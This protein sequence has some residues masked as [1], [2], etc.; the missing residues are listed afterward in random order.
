M[1]TTSSDTTTSSSA[2]F[3]LGAGASVDSGLPTYRGCGSIYGD[4]NESY[5]NILT[6]QNPPDKIWEILEPLY[7][8]IYNIKE[9]GETYK[10]LDK[11]ITLKHP[12]SMIVT[13][14]ID[15]LANNI[16]VPVVEL[17]NNYKYIDCLTCGE[18]C[19]YRPDH[20][21]IKCDSEKTMPD[22]VL[23]GDSI[24]RIKYDKIM[25]FIKRVKPKHV[26]IIGT[27]MQFNYLF[28]IVNR[29]K[30]YGAKCI[31]INPCVT[32]KHKK[33]KIMNMSSAEALNLLINE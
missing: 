31:N 29:A 19:E 11:L 30:Q 26:Y 32:Y 20:R 3:I 4:D 14:N 23:F 18:H 6:R 17:H 12:N 9:P 5:A 25:I 1:T 22:I 8:S 24:S 16:D 33:D 13:Q 15:S 28:T 27:S 2:L 10:L 7:N 21:C